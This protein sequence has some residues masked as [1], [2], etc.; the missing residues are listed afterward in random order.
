MLIQRKSIAKNLAYP[1]PTVQ[2]AD[3]PLFPV[4]I[5]IIFVYSAFT[6]YF[7]PHCTDELG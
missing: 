6:S 4:E 3:V 1:S 2:I 5:C 7:I